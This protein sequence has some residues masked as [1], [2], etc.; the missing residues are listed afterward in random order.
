MPEGN[1]TAVFLGAGAS[2]ALDLPLTRDILPEILRRLKAGTLFEGDIPNAPENRQALEELLQSI[3]RDEAA[4]PPLIT[5]L[6]SLVDHAVLQANPL[7]LEERRV[8][9]VAY[10]APRD[11]ARLR[12]L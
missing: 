1:S 2:K 8:N 9:A 12:T 10:R 3:L 5:D 4:K 7:A 11:L 6:L